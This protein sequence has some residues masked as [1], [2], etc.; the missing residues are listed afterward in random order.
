MSGHTIAEVAAAATGPAWFQLYFLG[1]RAGAEQLVDRAKH[2]GYRALLVTLDTPMPG[3][4]ESDA[5]HGLSPPLRLDRRTITKMAPRVLPRPRWLFDAA[6]DRFRL[7]LVNTTSLE[8]GGKTM[9][10]LEA[11]LHWLAY[12]AR[13]EDF[14]WLREQWEGPILAK[15]VLT[16]DDARRAVDAGADGVVVS[17]HGGRQ[18]DSVDPSIAAVVRVV[19]AVG[20]QVEVFIDGGVRR[21][22]DAVKAVALGAKAGDDRAGV[23]LWLGRGGPARRRPRAHPSAPGHRPDHAP[24]RG[25]ERG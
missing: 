2:A 3:N 21:G 1:G 15:G 13:W 12:P 11:L 6:R 14:G 4:R 9:S 7:D 17:N 20:D 16:A 19:K 25:Q 8:L 23:G 10:S 22:A 24:G 5:R 18:L